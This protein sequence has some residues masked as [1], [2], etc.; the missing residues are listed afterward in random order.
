MLYLDGFH[1]RTFL[2]EFYVVLMILVE[3]RRGGCRLRIGF[4][5]CQGQV[6]D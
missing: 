1:G 4:E 2:V 3:S 6:F 5:F